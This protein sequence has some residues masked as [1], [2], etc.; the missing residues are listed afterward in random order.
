MTYLLVDFS[1]FC[2]TA[3]WPAVAA[4]ESDPKYDV[5]QVFKNNLDTKLETVHRSLAENGITNFRTFF[6]EDRHAKAKFEAFPL[7]KSN[8]EKKEFVFDPKVVGKGYLSSRYHNAM[9][10]HSPDNEADDA[11]ASII[12]AMHQPGT[13]FV[14]ASSDRDLWQ[15]AAPD[16]KV[17]RLTANRFM[18]PE[19]VLKD[20]RTTRTELIPLYKALWGDSG[21]FVPNLCP[22]QQKQLMPLLEASRG[23]I[24][25][26]WRIYAEQRHNLSGRCR[27]LVDSNE[28]A[29]RTN[30]FLVK[31]QTSLPV[32]VEVSRATV[33]SADSAPERGE[34]Q[35]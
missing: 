8:R 24:D 1:N 19:D 11:I 21:D 13:D 17:F 5:E 22:R 23:S 35:Q 18:A 30:W 12:G 32:S 7:Y 6:V 26:F 31:L 29:I 2:H 10:A 16:V 4:H 25:D 3:Y 33:L 9:W 27:E 15:L 34:G 28:A 14:I 20:F